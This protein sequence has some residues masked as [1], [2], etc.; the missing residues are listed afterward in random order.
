[1]ILDFVTWNFFRVLDP[2]GPLENLDQLCRT[3]DVCP[4][5]DEPPVRLGS[6]GLLLDIGS[7]FSDIG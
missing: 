7:G 2:I 6:S 1:L 3:I 5:D 4:S